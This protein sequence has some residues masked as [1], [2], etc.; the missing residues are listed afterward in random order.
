MP[1]GYV[2]WT[3][4]G[5]SDTRIGAPV[6]RKAAFVGK[7][8]TLVGSTITVQ[9]T[10]PAWIADQFT[11]PAYDPVTSP[12]VPPTTDLYYVLIASGSKEG[13]YYEVTGNGANTLTVDPAGDTLAPDVANGT[14]I[15][16]IPY[17]TF[18]SLFPSG[19]GVHASQ[20]FGTRNSTILT[21]P[22]M[23]AGTSLANN[24]TYF[25]YDGSIGAPFDNAQ[26][27]K[28]GAPALNDFGKHPLA[29]DVQFIVR[30]NLPADT[31]ITPIGDVFTTEYRTPI[32][33]ITTGVNQDNA[34]FLTVPVDVT[35]NDSNLFQSGAFAGNGTFSAA[36]SDSLLVFDN[37]N[38]TQNK[39]NAKTYFYYTGTFFGGPG[40]RL[41]GDPNTIRN[42][43]VAF[44][45]DYQVLIRK[46]AGTAGTSI[47][48]MRPDYLDNL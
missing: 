14:S 19:E 21:L 9:G 39:A 35:L 36:G 28:V 3:A 30:H 43:E 38:A 25:Y 15:K 18:D 13:R 27:Q 44:S 48:D 2:T 4:K 7:V 34:V 20:N 47:W 33:I 5:N 8:D 46:K 32:N 11:D 45:L 41:A 12:D 6:H 40:W 16:L 37:T 26:W 1:M 10:S 17:W 42:A 29:P 24:A 23:T 31:E 22:T